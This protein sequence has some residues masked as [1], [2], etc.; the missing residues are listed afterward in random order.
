MLVALTVKAVVG[1]ICNGGDCADY[2]FTKQS[3]A[4]LPYLAI[5]VDS[6][7]RVRDGVTFALQ[8]T[9]YLILY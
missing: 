5:V 8:I 7:T 1:C 4:A 3:A 6:A 9:P 2:Q